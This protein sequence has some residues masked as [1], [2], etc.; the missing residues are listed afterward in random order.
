MTPSG[1]AISFYSAFVFGTLSVVILNND[2]SLLNSS[3][4][5]PVADVNIFASCVYYYYY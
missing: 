1:N 3:N 2:L 4:E 5:C